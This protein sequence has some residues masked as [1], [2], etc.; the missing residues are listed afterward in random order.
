MQIKIVMSLTAVA[1]IAS[2]VLLQT[3]RRKLGG[4][5]FGLTLALASP[6]IAWPSLMGLRKL[7]ILRRGPV[8]ALWRDWFNWS[9]PL[10][11]FVGLGA[12][13]RK[14][15]PGGRKSQW[16]AP[17]HAGNTDKPLG[18]ILQGEPSAHGTFLG[19]ANGWTN[20]FVTDKERESHM[21]L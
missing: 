3:G 7:G 20:I 18:R 11:L 8:G 14:A 15:G 4:L 13:F 19:T 9:G 1:A 5:L 6:F 21:Q 12:A 17:R 10:G 2:M 16:E